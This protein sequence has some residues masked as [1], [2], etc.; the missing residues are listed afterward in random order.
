MK[1]IKSCLGSAISLVLL[2]MAGYAGWRWGDPVFPRLERMVGIERVDR[3]VAAP[4]AEVAEAAAARYVRLIETGGPGEIRYD[5]NE[6]TSLLV[7]TL[8]GQLPTGVSDARV[9]LENQEATVSALLDLNRIPT[10]PDLGEF[11]SFLPDTVDVAVS[12]ALIP[13]DGP[14]AA[15]MVNRINAGGVRLPRRV[16]APLLESLGRS[17]EPGL[18]AEAIQVPLPEGVRSAYVEDGRLV[19]VAGS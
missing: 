17:D 4:S 1:S 7:H 9:R 12:G 10:F 2:V 15:L 8:G 16:I 3:T 5:Q 18:P 11:L 14:G 6:L 19:L 13:F